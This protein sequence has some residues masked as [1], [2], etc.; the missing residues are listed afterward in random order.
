MSKLSPRIRHVCADDLESLYTIDQICFVDGIA[1]ARTE[2]AFL[3]NH[4]EIIG[5][6]A[7]GLNGILGFILGYI[8]SSQ[9]AHIL[10]LDVLPDFRRH[11]I[12]TLLMNEFHRRHEEIRNVQYHSRSGC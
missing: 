4:P 8:E 11:S 2:F 10:T 7:E 12:G 5:S 9:C 6:V 3:L 1:F